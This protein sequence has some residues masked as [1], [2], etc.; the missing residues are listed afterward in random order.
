M[1]LL[2]HATL[3]PTKKE[4]LDA[5]L[6]SQEWAAE[7]PELTVVGSYRL[8]DPEGEVGVEGIVLGRVDG[9]FVHVP[10]TYRAAPLEGAEEHLV[11]TLE[12]SALGTR[13]VYDAEGD[14]VW[15]ATATATVLA[16]G[17]GAAEYF[18]VDG[19]R[20][21]RE[22]LVAVRGSGGAVEDPEAVV[23]HR[24]G[25]APDGDATLTGRWEGGEGVLVVVRSAA[26]R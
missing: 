20:E 2:H 14:P 8:D 6:P 23:V 16:G 12:H 22:P 11:G 9:G 17:S 7:L 15:H 1:A 10:L 4:L 26:S 19:V 21:T 18:E 5:W 24:V 13:W 3:T 25:E